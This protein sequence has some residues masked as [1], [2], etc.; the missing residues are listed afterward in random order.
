MPESVSHM[1]GNED[2]DPTQTSG[3]AATLLIS[4]F[5]HKNILLCHK[6]VSAEITFLQ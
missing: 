3:H 6:N 4:T 2:F 1:R 5:Q